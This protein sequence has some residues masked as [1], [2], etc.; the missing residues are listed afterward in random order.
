[1]QYSHRLIWNEVRRLG[2]RFAWA[3]WKDARITSAGVEI[4]PDRLLSLMQAALANRRPGIAELL[5]SGRWGAAVA[6]LAVLIG[7]ARASRWLASRGIHCGC[8]RREARLDAAGKAVVG[9]L[10][11]R[12]R[13][14]TTH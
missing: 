11:S 12:F 9:W 8:D 5:R 3:L 7:A 10:R 13:R 4:A 2:W 1:M 6:R 14:S